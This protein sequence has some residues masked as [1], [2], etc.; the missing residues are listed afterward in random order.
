MSD[1][2]NTHE[3]LWPRWLR[4][5]VVAAAT[6][7]LCSCRSVPDHSASHVAELPR[8]AMP[9]HSQYP[10]LPPHAFTGGSHDGC[11]AC[12]AAAAGGGSQAWKPPGISG[13]WPRE[14]YLCDGGD[15]ELPAKAHADFTVTGLEQEDTIAHFDTLDGRR[16]VQPSNRVCVY[17]PRFGAVRRIEGPDLNEGHDRIAGVEKRILPIRQDDL[18]IATTAIQPLQP[19]GQN[20]TK[21]SSTY[22][23][24]QQGGGLFGNQALDAMHDGFLPFENLD[25]IRRGIFAQADKARLATAVDAAITWSGD[26]AVQVTIEGKSAVVAT[27]NSTPEQVYRIDQPDSPALRIV[28]IA[29]THAARPGEFIDFT[30]RFDNVGDQRIGNVTILDNL[31][32]R[33]EYVPESQSCTVK[34]EFVTQPNQG[35]SQALRWE[36]QDPLEPGQGGIIRFRCKVR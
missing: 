15:Y 21:A 25:I 18:Q 22:R 27:G 1:A 3:D 31:A 28:K 7:I 23:E 36:I 35:G 16:L 34:A 6:L 9:Q 20:G 24:R 26:Q 14:E 2:A 11:A 8:A 17:A 33:L 13:P 4:L 5:S 30:L 10:T 19:V 32:T 12:A 29:S